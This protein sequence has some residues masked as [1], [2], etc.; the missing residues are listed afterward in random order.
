MARTRKGQ[1]LYAVP[2]INMTTNIRI[3]RALNSKLEGGN[4]NVIQNVLQSSSMDATNC[5]TF[6]LKKIAVRPLQLLVLESAL[7]I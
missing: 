4:L 3:W 6:L 1:N 5:T 2:L 7:L